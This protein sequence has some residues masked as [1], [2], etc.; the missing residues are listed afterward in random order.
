MKIGVFQPA[1][2]GTTLD[3][4]LRRLTAALEAQPVDLVV[5][6][7][8]FASGY[9]VGE[10]LER[11]AEPADGPTRE[12]FAAIARA[13][14][15]AILY[16]YPEAA[17]GRLYNSAACV[18]PDGALLANHRK[19]LNSPGSFEEDAFDLGDERTLFTYRDVTIGVVICFEVEL[20]EGVRDA[21]LH[22]AQLVLA[23]SALVSKWDVVARKMIPTRAFEN[24]VYLA[25]A[26]H[27]G[28]EN[29]FTYLGESRIVGPDGRDIAV[30]GSGE[31]MLVATLDVER[32]RAAQTR[33]PYLRNAT[34]L[35]S[36]AVAGH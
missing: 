28:T 23:P 35:L 15:A 29:G 12:A 13:T 8:L 1:C 27:G 9:N 11:L 31:D 4:R 21:A 32:V 6:P 17:D 5:C 3:E 34:R 14:G 20:C 24:G 2:G 26:N 10:E 30:A 36:R 25:Y 18:G 19:R 33:M 16:G 7:E 22:G